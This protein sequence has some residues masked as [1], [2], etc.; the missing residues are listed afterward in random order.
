[1]SASS[2]FSISNWKPTEHRVWRGSFDENDDRA[3]V[4]MPVGSDQRGTLAFIDVYILALKKWANEC[5]QRG[6]AHSIS[7]NMIAVAEVLMR[8]CTDFKD[9]RC[10][11][12]IATIMEMTGFA[13]PTVISLLARLREHKLLN[14]IRRTVR[15]GEERR[16]V[17]QTSNAY[18]IDMDSLPKQ[19]TGFLRQK[20]RG[21]IDLDKLPRFKGSPPLPPF[22]ERIMQKLVRRVTGAMTEDRR[23][24]TER[25]RLASR[26]AA[27]SD[28]AAKARLMWPDDPA[29]QQE[30][31]NASTSASIEP[32][33]SS[34]SSH[35]YH[36][37]NST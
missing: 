31:I 24:D 8:R 14:W 7:H 30:Y 28:P 19:I 35:E 4:K 27:T 18:F 5:K 12:Q 3:Q 26:I 9:G 36:P 10:T 17:Q 1:M 25:R 37:K 33:A 22:K 15:T 20:L 13:K 32:R 21:V 29:A 11:P 23:Q 16:P 2:P 6:R 34:G